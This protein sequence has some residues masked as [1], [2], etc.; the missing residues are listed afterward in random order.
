MAGLQNSSDGSGDPVPNDWE[1][2]HGLIKEMRQS[3]PEP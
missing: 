3:M 1:E 2:V